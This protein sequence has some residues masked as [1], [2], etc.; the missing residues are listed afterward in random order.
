MPRWFSLSLQCRRRFTL[1]YIDY[2]RLADWQM[3]AFSWHTAAS[4]TEIIHFQI[5][6]TPHI[7]DRDLSIFIVLRR[8]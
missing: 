7:V 4:Y 1:H 3:R 2:C 8:G 6:I 5:V